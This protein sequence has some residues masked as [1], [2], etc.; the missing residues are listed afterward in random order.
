MQKL[1]WDRLIFELEEKYGADIP[2]N[3]L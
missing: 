1:I 3:N 2:L